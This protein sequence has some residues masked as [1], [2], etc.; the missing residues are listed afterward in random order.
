VWLITATP[1]PKEEE[2]VKANNQILGFKRLK[3]SVES[4]HF[5]DIKKMLYLRNPESVR[6]ETITD[7]IPTEH[8]FVEYDLSNTEMML[9]QSELT[10]SL[11]KNPWGE[12]FLPVRQSL[13][14]P[15]ISQ[16]VLEQNSD[17]DPAILQTYNINQLFLCLRRNIVGSIT[18][19]RGKLSVARRVLDATNNSV[20]IVRGILSQG[21]LSVSDCLNTEEGLRLTG[22]ID[23]FFDS[24][25]YLPIKEI[26]MR[27]I[28]MDLWR[29]NRVGEHCLVVGRKDI[30]KYFNKHCAS[31]TKQEHFLAVM[32]VNANETARN[33][34]VRENQL[35]QMEADIG[36]YNQHQPDLQDALVKENGS[37]LA[38]LI[39]YLNDLYSCDRA[40]DNGMMV[41][42]KRERE[43]VV[44]F[45]MFEDFLTMTCRVLRDKAKIP[46][47]IFTNGDPQIRAEAISSFVDNRVDVLLLS[48]LTSSSG[49]NLQ[50]ASQVI[51]LDCPGH[52]V[53][54]GS[55]LEQQAI[56]RV[57]RMGQQNA[58]KILRFVGRG[59]VEMQ[60]FLEVAA[61]TKTA[62]SATLE[63]DQRDKYVC[64]G[65][66]Q[67]L[68]RIGHLVRVRVGGREGEVSVTGVSADAG[69]EKR[70]A[71]NEEKE[72]EEEDDDEDD[73]DVIEFRA[74]LGVEERVRLEMQ[75]A[76]LEGKIVVIDDDDD[77]EMCDTKDDL[78]K[79]NERVSCNSHVITPSPSSSSS[80][81]YS[82]SSLSVPDIKPD[83]Q[84][85]KE[86]RKR[87]RDE[88]DELARQA[89]EKMLRKMEKRRINAEKGL[90]PNTV[91][92][93]ID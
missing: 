11:D 8:V 60:M 45:S 80:M 9:Y 51:F 50:M 39:R 28:S 79:E 17:Y 29:D 93:V 46:C 67:P 64:D 56:G 18:Q 53:S 84:K 59:T 69:T 5:N 75:K 89:E 3:L 14:H 12:S 82:S 1:F 7:T 33:I 62:T 74:V 55:T 31:Y 44:I 26:A 19:Q 47:E 10:Y 54:E 41:G 30:V 85:I 13:C 23:V 35:I 25:S 92:I 37:K 57:V 43:K 32:E 66:A 78:H 86:E 58:V 63:K 91:V 73:D 61:A 76:Q 36:L 81:S 42:R 83:L 38:A 21:N 34:R 40:D 24:V 87:L 68:A 16:R 15:S 90:K 65:Y 88:Q 20:R 2:S 27:G 49:I 48:S 22:L 72:E 77:N 6:K 71:G 52:S 4:T 70:N